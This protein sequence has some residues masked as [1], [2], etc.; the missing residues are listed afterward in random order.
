MLED[1]E[2]ATEKAPTRDEI[3]EELSKKGIN[4]LVELLDALMPDETGGYKA[5]DWPQLAEETFFKLGP[6]SFTLTFPD[7]AITGDPDHVD[8]P[9]DIA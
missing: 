6:R 4:N 1:V 7:S 3:M 9:H 2:M 5:F 8:T